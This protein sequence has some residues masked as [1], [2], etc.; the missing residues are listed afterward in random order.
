MERALRVAG[1]DLLVSQLLVTGPRGNV[2]EAPRLVQ[3]GGNHVLARGMPS[4][5]SNVGSVVA[6][7]VLR[8]VFPILLPPNDGGA[9]R[10]RA[11]GELLGGV[12][13]GRVDALLV[14]LQSVHDLARL[15]AEHDGVAVCAARD[16]LVLIRVDV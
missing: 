15:A 1:G 11:E 2:I 10:G 7:Y 5:A 4:A 3:T 8:T 9:V 12:E 14:P 6:Q 13:D 16:H